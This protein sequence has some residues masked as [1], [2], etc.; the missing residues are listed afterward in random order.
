MNP[1][2]IKKGGRKPAPLRSGSKRRSRLV[3]IKTA[4]ECEG[5]RAEDRRKRRKVEHGII[6]YRGGGVS[7]SSTL[8]K[9]QEQRGEKAKGPRISMDGQAKRSR[10]PT[11]ITRG[12]CV[13][14]RGTQKKES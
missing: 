3:E 8:R 4:G 13:L 2:K 10:Q 9:R 12:S 5:S 11:N 14:L 6:I 7:M 1:Y